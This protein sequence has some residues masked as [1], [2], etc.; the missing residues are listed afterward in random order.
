M[1]LAQITHHGKGSHYLLH[2]TS[3]ALTIIHSA[4]A[5]V[6]FITIPLPQLLGDLFH[7][8]LG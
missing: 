2:T 7:E 3:L 5:A 8:A 4:P 1:R 6:T